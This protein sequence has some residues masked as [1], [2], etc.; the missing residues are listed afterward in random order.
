L[1]DY[2]S[3]ARG[4]AVALTK[5]TYALLDTVTAS[6]GSGWRS[7]PSLDIRGSYGA[8][9]CMSITNAASGTAG[10][11]GL[12]G[13]QIG[14]D[15]DNDGDADMWYWYGGGWG[16]GKSANATA[17]MAYELPFGVQFVRASYYCPTTIS[18]TMEAW[19][20]SIQEM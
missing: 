18:A 14:V 19:I 16:V 15:E 12:L 6:A 9:A 13:I 8:I 10:E 1:D 7:S 2:S 3:A 20:V 4:V 17:G 11:Q 5:T